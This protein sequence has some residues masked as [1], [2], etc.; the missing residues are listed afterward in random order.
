MVWAFAGNFSLFVLARVI[1]GLA[2]GN[3]SITTAAVADVYKS[4]ERGKGMVI[5]LFIVYNFI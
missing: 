4:N 1:G 3:V 2:K 5:Y